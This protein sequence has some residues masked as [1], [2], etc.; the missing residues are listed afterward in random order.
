MF[1]KRLLSWTVIEKLMIVLKKLIKTSHTLEAKFGIKLDL[2]KFNVT[3]LM[4]A[5]ITGNKF[6]ILKVFNNLKALEEANIIK[7]L[8][9]KNRLET[10]LND[11]MVIFK[12]KSSFIIC[13]LQLILSDGH[14]SVTDKLKNIETLNHFFYE[15]ERSPYGVMAELASLLSFKDNKTNFE[16]KITFENI[17]EFSIEGCRRAHSDKVESHSSQKKPF[18][19]S[20]CTQFYGEYENQYNFEYCAECNKYQCIKCLIAEKKYTE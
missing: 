10:P 8:K 6:E 19:C 11:A 20:H 13:E 9:I 3:D 16:S 7:I 5:M 2:V 15:I 1:N 17:A 14:Q 4:R 12:M 18:I